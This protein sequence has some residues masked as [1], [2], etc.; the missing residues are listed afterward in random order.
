MD[1]CCF[2]LKPQEFGAGKI[3]LNQGL[4]RR[5]NVG[6]HE[7]LSASDY[8]ASVFSHV[9][10]RPS[11]GIYDQYREPVIAMLIEKLV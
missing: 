2:F 11:V 9:P 4:D 3:A 1:P 5:T 8:F 6:C 10:L 7:N